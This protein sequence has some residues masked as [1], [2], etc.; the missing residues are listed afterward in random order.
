M[1]STKEMQRRA[2]LRKAAAV[3]AAVSAVLNK[4][5]PDSSTN[6]YTISVDLPPAEL[7]SWLIRRECPKAAASVKVGDGYLSTFVMSGSLSVASAISNFIRLGLRYESNL[8]VQM[9]DAATDM[10][11]FA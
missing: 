6:F 2:K 1:A 9:I 11:S 8:P 10:F 7:K 5:L 4:V 3:S